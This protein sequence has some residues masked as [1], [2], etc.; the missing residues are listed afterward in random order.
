[1]GQLLKLIEIR[2]SSGVLLVARAGTLPAVM[3]RASDDQRRDSTIRRLTQ[4]RAAVMQ[5]RAQWQNV[6]SA[7]APEAF[8][9]T[10]LVLA[11]QR[12]LNARSIEAVFLRTPHMPLGP[13]DLANITT[14][15]INV[16]TNQKRLII[17]RKG[18]LPP[19]ALQHLNPAEA[20]AVLRQLR[21]GDE[22]ARQLDRQAGRLLPDGMPRLQGAWLRRFL[23]QQVSQGALDAAVIGQATVAARLAARPDAEPPVGKMGS[24]ERIGEA[25]KRSPPYAAQAGGEAIKAAVEA[26]L[27]PENIAIM[28]ALAAGV[29]LANTNP[30]TGA[31]VNTTLVLLAWAN[32]GL[33][34]VKGIGAFVLA[35]V[36]AESANTNAELE[37]AAKAYGEALGTMGPDL[38]MAIVGRFVPKSAGG[39]S[40]R[41]A[42]PVSNAGAAPRQQ[43]PRAAKRAAPASA[44]PSQGPAKKT[45]TAADTPPKRQNL[46]EQYMGR[47]PGKSSRTGKEVIE[48]MR[49]DGTLRTNPSTGKT[50]FKASNGK[51]YPLS[52]ADMAHR[53]DAVTWWNNVGRNHGPKSPEVRKF[54]LDSKNYVLDHYS[55]NRSSGAVLG[56][57]QQY[58]PPRTGN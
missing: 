21:E 55:L 8:S 14:G 29:A 3:L 44:P 20:V 37:S 4:D 9:A 22:T 35:T 7:R 38:L 23:A 49:A 42:V 57:S 17:A 10:D 18:M 48:R 27:Q 5:L 25:L 11:L 16:G 30:L 45:K 58:M 15:A 34:A 36:Q 19:E 13:A 6:F 31:A 12:E 24:L 51:W 50:I 54:M 39:G 47:T 28:V 53:T 40:G 2:C 32:G 33:K 41:S 52:D 26:F 56:Q 43:P 46:R 1:M